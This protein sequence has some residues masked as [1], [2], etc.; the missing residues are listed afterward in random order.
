MEIIKTLCIMLIG[1]S[2]GIVIAGAVFAFIAII[3]VVPRFAQKT[4]TTNKIILYEEAIILGGIF[5]S[6]EYLFEFQIPLNA[7][8]VI[9][10][11][12][13]VGI[14]YGVLA[15][16]LAEVLDVIPIIRRR[17]NIHKGIALFITV[18]AIGKLTGGLVD[19]L[20]K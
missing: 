7:V 1:L 5:G 14:F 20:I 18:L 19:I 12:L 3:G 11:A 17:L 10:Y 6:L 13:F 4:N 16:S 2:S 15:V 9:I 8:F